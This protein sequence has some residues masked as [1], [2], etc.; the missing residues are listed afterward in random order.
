MCL[1]WSSC[2]GYLVLDIKPR[3]CVI[4]HWVSP[5]HSVGELRCSMAPGACG[6]T[7]K[8]PGEHQN[9]HWKRVQKSK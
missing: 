1:P 9:P 6:L 3:S 8:N 2:S 7:Q 4:T 5:D